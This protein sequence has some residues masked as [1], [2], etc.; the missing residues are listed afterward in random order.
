MR[1]TTIMIAAATV[2]A[3]TAA[4][5]GGDDGASTY[6]TTREGQAP[7]PRDTRPPDTRTPQT[8]PTTPGTIVLPTFPPTSST[9]EPPA[10]TGAPTSTLP[11]AGD[12]SVTET[13]F[14]DDGDGGITWGATYASAAASASEY[15]P[16]EARFLDA[17]GA[18]L[19]TSESTISLLLPGEG[20]VTD[21][22][23]EVEG[24]VAS[25]EVAIGEG[26]PT[27][28]EPAGELT[29][30]GLA[31][32]EATAAA[33]G[34]I[35]STYATDLDDVTVVGV[36][37][38]DAGAI[39][40]IVDTYVRIVQ[41]AGDTWFSLTPPADVA[42]VPATVFVTPL[43]SPYRNDPPDAALAVQESWFVGSP[44]D[45]YTWGS[46]V[47]NS[48]TSS[49]SGPYLTAKFFDAEDRLI[50]ADDAYFSYLRPGANAALAY[51]WSTPVAIARVEVTLTDGGGAEEP[52]A[53]ELTVADLAVDASSTYPV[54]TGTVTSTFTEAVTY[55]ELIFVW[56]DAA[57]AVVYA[58]STY[59]E[60]IPAGGTGDIEVT[61]Y[62]TGAPTTPP[63]ETY[64]LI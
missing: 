45:G 35:T 5:C 38:D 58:T 62:E 44:A 10:T 43:P 20:A 6:E 50:D 14:A 37:R 49:W 11:A 27:E 40:G 60:E 13:W 29:T 9:D 1:R 3:V 53:G 12:V 55:P 33:T 39:T 23:Y 64:W 15:A 18:V 21:V 46:I 30:G 52:P 47:T 32:D 54:L 28:F 7:P 26:D 61:L 19:G 56:R 34:R 59:P 31:V 2:L 16:V 36:W 8:D 42:G 63:T 24:T 17:D 41:A 22:E 4:A 51:V 57:G 48:G 25:I